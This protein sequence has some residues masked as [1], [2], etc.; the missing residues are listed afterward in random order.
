MAEY[1][2]SDFLEELYSPA[3]RLDVDHDR[4]ATSRDQATEDTRFDDWVER[5]DCHGRL[6]WEKPGLPDS[7]RW[8][9]FFDFEELPESPAYRFHE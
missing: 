9:A 6:G 3:R 2:A 7:Q 1:D 5:P 4:R 8:W